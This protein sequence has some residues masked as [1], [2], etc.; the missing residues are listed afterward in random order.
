MKHH[1]AAYLKSKEGFLMTYVSTIKPSLKILKN[2][3]S[4]FQG[5]KNSAIFLTRQVKFSFSVHRFEVVRFLYAQQLCVE[6]ALAAVG[7]LLWS[8]PWGQ[9]VLYLGLLYHYLPPYCNLY[10]VH[11]FGHFFAYPELQLTKTHSWYLIFVDQ[12][13][14]QFTH[15]A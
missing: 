8:S 14:W 11:S 4:F 12:D 5:S 10:L 13:L 7:R 9:R 15:M 6:A 1:L 2:S 3:I